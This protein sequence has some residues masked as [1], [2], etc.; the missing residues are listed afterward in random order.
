MDHKVRVDQKRSAAKAAMEQRKKEQLLSL[1]FPPPPPGVKPSNVDKP[2]PVQKKP[3]LR[4]YHFDPAKGLIY[5]SRERILRTAQ[6]QRFDPKYMAMLVKSGR[7]P[8]PP[9]M[10]HRPPPP[11][12][13]A[14][15]MLQEFFTLHPPPPLHHVMPH[16]LR[17]PPP[18][19]AAPTVA[20][21]ASQPI[22]VLGAQ[23]YPCYP[24]TTTP[25]P[26]A[27]ATAPLPVPLPLP[28]PPPLPVPAI[29]TTTSP[30]TATPPPFFTPP[31]LPTL[32][33]HFKVQPLA[34]MREIMPVDI[35]QKIGPLP[36]TLDLD[37]GNPG[38]DE[39]Q[40]DLTE[41]SAAPTLEN[42]GDV[43]T[44]PQQMQEA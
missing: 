28:L 31:P 35:L 15:A 19:V 2:V 7:L 42:A 14:D 38:Q 6:P 3:K 36:K 4:Y 25:A 26:A 13:Q 5:K 16:Y 37:V 18:S 32:S 39:P 17:G 1:P 24:L 21:A 11:P 44:P 8:M 34:S 12:A 41:V 22:P 40:A 20:V 27:A 33:S 30:L 10:R 23:N 43:Q 9:F 29:T